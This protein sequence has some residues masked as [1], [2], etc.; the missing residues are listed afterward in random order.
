MV[1]ST[2]PSMK[3][4]KPEPATHPEHRV[5]AAPDEGVKE[6]EREVSPVEDHDVAWLHGVEMGERGGPFV[7]VD[8]QAEVHRRPRVQPVEAGHQALRVVACR[9]GKREAGLD[10]RTRQ[11]H[12][13]SVNGERAMALPP[14]VGAVVPKNLAVQIEEQVL[15]NLCASLADRRG[16]HGLALRQG[17]AELAALVPQLGE[18]GRIALA[19]ARQDEAG[20]RTARRS[21]CRGSACASS[22]GGRARRRVRRPHR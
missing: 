7:G 14:P 15:V 17:D 22:I 12:L 3:S 13:G 19:P 1:S 9:I 20:T 4:S 18:D 11:V 8:R 6:H 2:S 10:Q 16:G 5:R 21:G